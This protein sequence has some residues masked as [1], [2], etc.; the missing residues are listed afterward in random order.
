ML[1]AAGNLSNLLLAMKMRI[2]RMRAQAGY[3]N[4]T[5]VNGGHIALPSGIKGSDPVKAAINYKV[6]NR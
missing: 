4:V 5:Y 2:R 6:N 3:R 1:D